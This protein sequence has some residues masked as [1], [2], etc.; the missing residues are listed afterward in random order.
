MKY[1]AV[2]NEADHKLATATHLTICPS[3][4]INHK[5]YSTT[6]A[7]LTPGVAPSVLATALD[8]IT[9]FTTPVQAFLRTIL[10]CLQHEASIFDDPDGDPYEALLDLDLTEPIQFME[11]ITA[12]EDHLAELSKGTWR[13]LSDSATL[14]LLTQNPYTPLP[15]NLQ[16]TLIRPSHPNERLMLFPTITVYLPPT[17]SYTELLATATEALNRLP[18]IPDSPQTIKPQIGLYPA[19]FTIQFTS[20]PQTPTYLR[21]KL[22]T[23]QQFFQDRFHHT[24]TPTNGATVPTVAT[25]EQALLTSYYRPFETQDAP[26]PA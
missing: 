3:D 22:T 21:D 5:Y 20:T 15:I 13:G 7:M 10:A 18:T 2:R 6:Q 4:A 16:P 11:I 8:E 23:L 9:T 12:S 24:F 1:P 25:L 26:S 17:L 14:T 19:G